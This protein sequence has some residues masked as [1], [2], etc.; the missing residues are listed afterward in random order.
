MEEL[1]DECSGRLYFT[2]NVFCVEEHE[3]F[4]LIENKDGIG[5]WP[6][7]PGIGYARTCGNFHTAQ[8]CMGDVPGAKRTEN[9]TGA[10]KAPQSVTCQHH[11]KG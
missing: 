4:L 8:G 1:M 7:R 3:K 5:S 2:E 6:G 9:R 11:P 10:R